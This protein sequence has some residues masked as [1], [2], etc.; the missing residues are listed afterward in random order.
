MSLD[1]VTKL[2]AIIRQGDNI[3]TREDSLNELLFS[4]NTAV[5]AVEELR[6]ANQ[7]LLYS[8]VRCL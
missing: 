3:F 6:E 4:L 8:T 2:T 7:C 5:I 1:E